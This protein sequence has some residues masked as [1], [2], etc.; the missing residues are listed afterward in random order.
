MSTKNVKKY[1]I[2]LYV[3]SDN[4]IGAFFVL[5]HE[6]YSGP[7]VKFGEGK[8]KFSELVSFLSKTMTN[9]PDDMEKSVKIK[10]VEITTPSKEAGWKKPLTSEELESV[11]KALR[12]NNPSIEFS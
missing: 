12:K 7:Y 4:H 5:P 2:E 11:R 8:H 6:I 10:Y 3:T 1:P 9:L